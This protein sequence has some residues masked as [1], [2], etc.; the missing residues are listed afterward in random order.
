MVEK[1]KTHAPPTAAAQELDVCDNLLSGGLEPLASFTAL[2]RLVCSQNQLTGSMLPLQGLSS[3]CE[4][5]VDRNRLT[6]GLD[7]LSGCQVP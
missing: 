1:M 6:G 4:L 2:L 3:L 5:C 7:P